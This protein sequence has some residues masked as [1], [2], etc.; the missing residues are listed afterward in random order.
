MI[1]IFL[2]SGLICLCTAAAKAQVHKIYDERIRSLQVVANEDWLNLPVISLQDGKID[3]DFDDLT[4]QY[5]RYTYKIEHCEYD[6][7][8]SSE[9]FSSDYLYGF[10][11]GNTIDDAQESINTNTLYTHYH[12]TLPNDKCRFKISGNYRL[13]LFR[14]NEDN[15]PVLEACFMIAE[16][17]V[18]IRMEETSNT[19][20][21]NNGRY[22]QLSLQVKYNGLRV[23]NPQ[24]QLKTVVMQN[25][26]WHDARVNVK[27]QF[28]MAD[29]LQWQ[30]CRDYIFTAGN[31]YHKFEMLST[32]NPSMGVERLDW[33]GKSYNAYPYVDTPRRN[34][35]YD[36]SAQGAFVL[37][38]S[39]NVE[40]STT[41]D[42]MN[43]HF[44]LKCAEAT[45][46]DVY[47]NGDWTYDS[48]SDAYKLT[49]DKS[50]HSYKATVPLKLGY[51]SYQYLLKDF[52]GK[53]VSPPFEGSFYETKNTYQT[54]VYY[55]ANG[56]RTDRLV[57]YATLEQ[58]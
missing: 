35:L 34:Y 4:H 15:T 18:G 20:I 17:K 21:E 38:N 57:G 46:G 19:D 25:R 6:W 3:I 5:E 9:L 16:Q 32:D 52:T 12:L 40:S 48:F 33:D 10:A 23:D 1:K 50:T 47:L 24:T 56:D 55:R 43:V 42:Y 54:L 45:Q 22:Q 2:L 53:I 26:Q 39:D 37:R 44:E 51:Y 58:R 11:S 28:T 41:S 36:E 27:P 7:S 14:E 13:T 30:H 31:E 29:G 8:T 49:Y